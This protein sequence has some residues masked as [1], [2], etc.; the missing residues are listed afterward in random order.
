MTVTFPLKCT[1]GLRTAASFSASFHFSIFGAPGEEMEAFGWSN[2][3]EYSPK[4]GTKYEGACA[5]CCC[6]I[7]RAVLRVVHSSATRCDA[8]APAA[9]VIVVVQ[10]D[11]TRTAACSS[12][13]PR[14]DFAPR[15]CCTACQNFAQPTK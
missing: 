6:S 7:I 8:F 5:L 3:P 11:S 10:E 9:E 14:T 1:N 4:I 12:I 2:Y 15:C 13:N